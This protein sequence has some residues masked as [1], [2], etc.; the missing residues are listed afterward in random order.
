MKF[1]EI[2]ISTTTEGQ[3]LVADVLWNYTNYGV[4]IS[5]VKDV[6]ELVNDRRSTWDYIDDEVLKELNE[7]VTLVKAYIAFDIT[8]E[9]LPEIYADL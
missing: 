5:D 2:T 7:K 3:E 9:T 1:T 4:A 6:A 8:E